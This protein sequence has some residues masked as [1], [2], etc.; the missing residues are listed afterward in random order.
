MWP[1]LLENMV[2]L[3]MRNGN[4]LCLSHSQPLSDKQISHNPGPWG[5]KHLSQRQVGQGG[6]GADSQIVQQLAPDLFL[7]LGAGLGRQAMVREQLAQLGHPLT[8]CTIH[9][10]YPGGQVGV[11]PDV[12]W[13]FNICTLQKT[14]GVLILPYTIAYNSNAYHIHFRRIPIV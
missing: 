4:P 7:D 9:L 14:Y 1:Y 6:H 10:S 8:I 13:A 2:S 3:I 5:L 12:P 11:G